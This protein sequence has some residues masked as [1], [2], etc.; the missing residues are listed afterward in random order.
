MQRLTQ[1]VSYAHC[2]AALDFQLLG[3]APGI[4]H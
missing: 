4:T 3:A 1:V 2:I